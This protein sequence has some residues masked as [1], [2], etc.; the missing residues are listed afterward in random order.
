[1]GTFQ[2]WFSGLPYASGRVGSAMPC[3]T[4]VCHSAVSR[5]YISLAF[6]VAVANSTLDL[7]AFPGRYFSPLALHLDWPA[8]VERYACMRAAE[9]HRRPPRMRP[10][11]GNFVI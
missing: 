11:P 10:H 7:H 9:H 3:D 2:E 6:L 8:V 1:M 5:T 4:C